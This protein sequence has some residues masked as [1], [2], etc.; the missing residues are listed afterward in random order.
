MLR[1]GIAGSSH[2]ACRQTTPSGGESERW[3][4]GR[5]GIPTSEV[6]LRS[7][8]EMACIALPCGR[9]VTLTSLVPPT[10]KMPISTNSHLKNLSFKILRGCVIRLPRSGLNRR[11]RAG[12]VLWPP[13]W[14]SGKS[15]ITHPLRDRTRCPRE[16]A[17]LDNRSRYRSP[18]TGTLGRKDRGRAY[19]EQADAPF[20]NL[21]RRPV[22]RAGHGR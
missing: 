5:T 20:R 1:C 9:C 6:L 11:H 22:P 3:P 13:V 12:S 18:R 7:T 2:P 4:R 14:R 16:H 8:L 10:T 19:R 15:D 17:A 21:S